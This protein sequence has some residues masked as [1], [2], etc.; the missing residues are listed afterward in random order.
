MSSAISRLMSRAVA[1]PLLCMVAVAA[2]LGLEVQQLVRLGQWVDHTHQ[3]LGAAEQAGRLVAERQNSVRGYALTHNPELLDG[4]REAQ[5]ELPATLQRLEALVEDNP[6]QRERALRVQALSDRWTKL[7]DEAIVQL[8]QGRDAAD[9]RATQAGQGQQLMTRLGQELDEL[10]RVER[11]LLTER[12]ERA[13][14]AARLVTGS[15][16]GL[17]LLLGLLL[18]LWSRRM[19]ARV[20]EE[21]AGA[22]GAARDA[23]AMREQFL[24]VAAH[25]LRTP[26]TS[27]LLQLQRV[28]R[29]ATK[30][31]MFSEAAR[32][33][34]RQ[35][36][37]LTGLIDAL[38]AANELASDHAP[39]LKRAPAELSEVARAAAERVAREEV[40][41][42]GLL[43][44]KP[45]ARP[46]L[47]MWDRARLEHAV[48][49]LL[50]NASKFGEGR[51][52]VLEVGEQGEQAFVAVT[53]SG[54]GIDLEQ[55]QK[56]FGRFTRGVSERSYG[57]FGLGLF[58]AR[59][60][61]ELHG[62]T[63]EVTS[64]PGSGARFTLRIPRA[65]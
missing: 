16:V 27:L 38:I 58:A 45:P 30:S 23:L 3:V 53:D 46:V 14:A 63:V 39:A 44:L 49:A 51:P 52:V 13:T 8:G 32:V 24:N 29:D 1:L 41:L 50:S 40:H 6:A 20:S 55:Q 34:L 26:L 22:L 19:I 65:A 35:A 25:E 33:S 2:L 48:A 47:G 31:G 64:A 11:A 4:Y 57:G 28:E 59:R 18:A 21:Y 61:A 12:T 17:V 36:R 54:I 60:I 42:P 7:A 62:G 15:G 9:V 5:Q 37:R 10:S 56:I 43:E